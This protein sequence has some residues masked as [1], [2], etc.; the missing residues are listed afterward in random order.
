MPNINDL[1]EN[2]KKQGRDF[3]ESANNLVQRLTDGAEITEEIGEYTIYLRRHTWQNRCTKGHKHRY[4]AI[5]LDKEGK[6]PS[7]YRTKS[8]ER[9][10]AFYDFCFLPFTE[11]LRDENNYASKLIEQ[12]RTKIRSDHKI[13]SAEGII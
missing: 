2:A 13:Q 1:S 8:P 6:T 10:L 11:Q 5:V 4:K 12:L 9:F 3:L 7:K